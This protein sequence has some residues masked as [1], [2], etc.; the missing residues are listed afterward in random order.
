M[1]GQL[2]VRRQQEM[3]ER[4]LAQDHLNRTRL[5]AEV[6]WQQCPLIQ[7]ISG[8]LQAARPRVFLGPAGAQVES[9][10]SR[11]GL[12]Y[13]DVFVDKYNYKQPGAGPGPGPGPLGK[14]PGTQG[15]PPQAPAQVRGLASIRT[16]LSLTALNKF[17][18]HGLKIYLE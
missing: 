13:P 11:E 1:T 5:T 3:Q 9:A 4:F 15:H 10:F 18:L 12:R 6:G 2:A 14:A 8:L 17:L 16:D 7:D